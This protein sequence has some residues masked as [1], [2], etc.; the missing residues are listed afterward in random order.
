MT[1]FVLTD[2]KD[3]STMEV[4]QTDENKKVLKR[5]YIFA[6]PTGY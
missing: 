4:V 1:G 2:G 5:G 6:L 3:I